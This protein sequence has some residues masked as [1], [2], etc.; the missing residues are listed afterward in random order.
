MGS[1]LRIPQSWFKIILLSSILICLTIF[2][3][4]TDFHAVLMQLQQIGIRFIGFIAITALAYF[5]ATWSWHVCF[6]A[7]QK[8]VSL[9]KL[10]SIRQVG[11]TVGQFNPTSIIAGDVLKVQ[12]LKTTKIHEDTITNTVLVSRITAVLSQLALVIFAGIWLIFSSQGQVIIQAI[13]IPFYVLF[14]ILILAK[15]L[16]L[17]WLSYAKPKNIA[18]RNPLERNNWF[19]KTKKQWKDILNQIQQFYRQQQQLF[20][21][22]YALSLVHWIVGGL[23]FYLILRFLSIDLS[24]MQGIVLDMSVLMIKSLGAFIPGQLGI[25]EMGNKLMLQTLGISVGATWITVSILR[26]TR[27]LI[28]VMI[29]FILYLFIK[30]EKPQ[31]SHA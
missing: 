17:Y 30:K 27:Q 26:R 11:E 18:P 13:R 14:I 9:Y 24:I 25:E 8:N 28:W 31:L 20:W 21:R 12:L 29:G 19:T 6:G 7:Y 1:V 10:F 15:G 16:L 22:S 5:F 2:V 23:E 4:N 3:W